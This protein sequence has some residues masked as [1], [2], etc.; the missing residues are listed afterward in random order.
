MHFSKFVDR[1]QGII[2][3]NNPMGDRADDLYNQKANNELEKDLQ[4]LGMIYKRIQGSYNGHEED[5]FEINNIDFA[6]LVSLGQKYQQ[7]A[8]IFGSKMVSC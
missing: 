8:V 7:K 3:A 4:Q 5:A 6:T 2:T 1:A